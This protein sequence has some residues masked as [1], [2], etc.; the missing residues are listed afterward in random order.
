MSAIAS[1]PKNSRLI[2][3]DPVCGDGVLAARLRAQGD[4]RPVRVPHHAAAGRR[5]PATVDA[6]ADA[7]A[8]AVH[9]LSASGTSK[10]RETH[11][12]TE[13]PPAETDHVRRPLDLELVVMKCPPRFGICP[14]RLRP[15]SLRTTVPDPRFADECPVAADRPH[16]PGLRLVDCCCRMVSKS[17]LTKPRQR[18]P[19]VEH[20]RTTTETL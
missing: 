16:S 10:C 19:R 14:P 11:D 18:R 5:D 9:P 15:R 17:A 20:E 4:R 13:G 3:A 1:P 8:L 6:E 12:A 2:A 7:D